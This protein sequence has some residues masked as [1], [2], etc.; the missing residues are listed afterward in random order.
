MPEQRQ[1]LVDE[2]EI[3]AD[4]LT[5]DK[6]TELD[7]TVDQTL[8]SSMHVGETIHSTENDKGWSTIK[9]IS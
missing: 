8:L 5:E 3:W 7:I 9:R 1:Y 4:T 6:L 2:N